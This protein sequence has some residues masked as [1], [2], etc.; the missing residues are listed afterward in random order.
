MPPLLHLRT[1]NPHV[2][3]ALEGSQRA[4]FLNRT[5]RSPVPSL[6]SCIQSGINSFGIQG[7]NAH[8]ALS[9]LHQIVQ[10]RRVTSTGC[11]RQLSWPFPPK[12]EL[13]TKSVTRAPQE[14]RIEWQIDAASAQMLRGLQLRAGHSLPAGVLA[15]AAIS[16]LMLSVDGE[17]TACLVLGTLSF[18]PGIYSGRSVYTAI[19][20]GR[21]GQIQIRGA[22]ASA[23]QVQLAAL[24][25]SSPPQEMGLRHLADADVEVQPLVLGVSKSR[26]AKLAVCMLPSSPLASA[27]Q[28]HMLQPGVLEATEQ[29]IQASNSSLFSIRLQPRQLASVDI[30]AVE[31]QF[32][33]CR[34][35]LSSEAC[36]SVAEQQAIGESIAMQGIQLSSIELRGS[37]SEA[38]GL[39]L[40]GA[41]LY[42][43]PTV[44]LL[45]TF[46]DS[47]VSRHMT[48]AEASRPQL[49][50]DE[51]PYTDLD[52]E[53]GAL[54][55]ADEDAYD[56]EN[57]PA[58][59]V[60]RTLHDRSPTP[61][62]FIA[63]LA[64]GGQRAYY[65]F[66][67]HFLNWTRPHPMYSL[68]H[69]TL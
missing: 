13:I 38:T 60:L 51:R 6:S 53:N 25:T 9:P 52:G 44:E 20:N 61:I 11:E 45:L 8:V 54:P 67:R 27:Q 15:S 49:P 36:L 48:N 58:H 30:L 40:P 43:N 66:A 63:P 1:V 41:L 22:S 18:S 62:F 3:Q 46:V 14:I 4:S 34:T 32:E 65:N 24:V 5:N 57:E 39:E 50:E 56:D 12:H 28:G 2:G 47:E 7:T 64:V 17:A 26:Q 68:D 29:L 69:D 10:C 21:N 33:S 35:A 42:E 23:S 37:L 19:I 16:S 59:T 31:Q 55:V